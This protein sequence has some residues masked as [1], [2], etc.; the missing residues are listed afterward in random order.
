MNKPKVRAVQW[1]WYLF[2]ALFVNACNRWI[3]APLV[4]DFAMLGVLADM[5]I[6]LVWLTTIPKASRKRW[7]SFTIFSLLL[8]QGLSSI[9]FYG[10]ADRV[11]VGALMTVGLFVIA[12]WF[13]RIRVLPLVLATAALIVANAV[14]P[15]SDWPFLTHFRVAYDTKLSVQPSDFPALPMA[16]IATPGGHAVVTVDQYKM[17][18][19]D[20][21]AAALNAVKSPEALQNFLQNYKHLYRFVTI[22]EHNGHF[23]QHDSTPQELAEVKLNDLLSTFFPFNQASW[24]VIGKQVV[25]YMSPS[26]SASLLMNMT[27]H[28]AS[29][30]KSIVDFSDQVEQQELQDWRQALTSIGAQP[31]IPALSIVGRRLQGQVDGHRIDVQVSDS[32]ILGFGSFTAPNVHQVLLEGENRLDVV[33]LDQGHGKLVSTYHGSADMP[34]PND[35]VIGP[36][37]ASG[38]DAVFVNTQPAYILTASGTNWKK[39]Y[40]AP[41]QSLRFEAALKWSKDKAPEII[42]D[43]PSYLRNSPTRYFTSYTYRNGQL[44]RNWRVYETN[45]VDV[46]PVQFETN[47]PHYIVAAIYSTGKFLVLRRQFVPVLPITVGLLIVTAL[48]GWLL[49]GLERRKNRE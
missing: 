28:S 27:N 41:N 6:V 14:L 23:S 33:S 24:S 46:H 19:K 9:A 2:W 35:I 12:W 4:Q 29:L 48:G 37:N 8:G 1:L 16:V 22:S 25:Q 31:S 36:I 17:S 20:F 21:A 15:E 7:I 43:D 13:G 5:A 47:G 42:T 40:Q 32:Q 49:R 44:Y 10:L 26:G 11:L 45:V 39:V 34:L 38:T 18:Q 3:I 30:P